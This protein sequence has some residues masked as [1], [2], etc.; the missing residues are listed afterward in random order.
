MNVINKC[1]YA[2]KLEVFGNDIIGRKSYTRLKRHMRAFKVDVNHG[3]RKWATRMDDLQSYLPHLLWEAGESCGKE[4]APFGEH[5][6]REILDGAI[7]KQ[8]QAK[9]IRLLNT[10]G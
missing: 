3:I 8:Q 4:L 10:L 2:L 9:L 5:K 6:M 7:H 1:L